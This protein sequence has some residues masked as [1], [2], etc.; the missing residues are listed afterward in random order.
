MGRGQTSLQ[1]D[2]FLLALSTC[3]KLA[4]EAKVTAQ[5]DR[6]GPQVRVLLSLREAGQRKSPKLL[7]VVPSFED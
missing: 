7:R 3:A 1:V 6:L 2:A 4:T 5:E